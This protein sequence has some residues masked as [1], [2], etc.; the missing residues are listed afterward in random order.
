MVTERISIVT[1]AGMGPSVGKY[2][3]MAYL[4]PELAVEG[5]A[6]GVKYRTSSIRSPWRS[7]G[8]RRCSIPTTRG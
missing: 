4:P 3:L 6:F 8:R 7:P 1:T 2:L 5:T